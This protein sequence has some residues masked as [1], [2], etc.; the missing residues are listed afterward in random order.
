MSQNQTKWTKDLLR[1]HIDELEQYTQRLKELVE[2]E[3]K[4]DT[5]GVLKAD[6]T[7]PPG[8]VSPTPPGH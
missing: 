4:W 5:G 3:T 2:D 1:T 7:V 6:E 8:P